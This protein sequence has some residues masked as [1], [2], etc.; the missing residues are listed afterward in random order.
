MYVI[1]NTVVNNAVTSYS[2]TFRA[3]LDFLAADGETVERTLSGQDIGRVTIEHAQ[4]ETDTV[5]IGGVLSRKAEIKI[6]NGYVPK[7]GDVFAL[8]LYLLDL[9][10]TNTDPASQATVGQWT[11]GELTTYTHREI[12]TLPPTKDIDGTPLENYYIPFGVYEVR[13]AVTEGSTVKVTAFDKLYAVDAFYDPEIEF[14]ASSVAVTEDV[15]R[16]LGIPGRVPVSTGNLIEAG[17]QPVHGSDDEEILVSAEYSFTIAAEDVSGLACRDVLGGIAAMSG[18]NGLLDRNGRYMVE[19]IRQAVPRIDLDTIDTPQI[20][21]EDQ[22]ITGLSCVVS[23]QVT[24]T[25][26]IQDAP[27]EFRCPWMTQQRLNRLLTELSHVSWR[28]AV[29]EQRLG[30]PRWDLGDRFDYIP[31]YVPGRE[32]KV[33]RPLITELRFEF[34]GGLSAELTSCGT[35]EVI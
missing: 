1:D 6:C 5:Q 17:R 2:R 29:F 22:K 30:D 10:G 23:D 33:S 35:L 25:S 28:P 26:G 19:F 13:R 7:R 24:L 14:P 31:P 18:G 4:T 16:Q 15:L 27:V 12:A 11:H 8:Y 34:D 20:G 3:R 21:D 32:T 9:D